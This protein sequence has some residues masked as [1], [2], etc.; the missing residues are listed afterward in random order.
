MPG[1]KVGLYFFTLLPL[2]ISVIV[3]YLN[4]TDYFL[5]GLVGASTGPVFYLICKWI[6]GGMTKNNPK[7]YPLNPRT[8]LAAGDTFRVGAYSLFTGLMGVTGSFFLSWYEG[9]WGEGYY[10]EEAESAFFTDFWWMI[11]MIRYV[12]IALLAV[13]AV[14]FLLGRSV[15]GRKS[16]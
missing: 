8:K 3:Y 16:R 10:A 13:A 7:R 2:V 9:D 1:G 14:M 11:D 6:Y 4:G 15:E 12:G 5:I